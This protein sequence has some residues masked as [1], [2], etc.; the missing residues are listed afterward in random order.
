MGGF[1]HDTRLGEGGHWFTCEPEDAHVRIPDT[2]LKCVCFLCVEG[3]DSQG[4]RWRY[5]GTGFFL[6]VMSDVIPDQGSVYLVTAKHCVERA[7][8]YGAL[9]LRLNTVD[10]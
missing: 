10:G 4:V 9:Y 7:Q 2:L 3:R 5:G 1:Y 8:Q 6:V